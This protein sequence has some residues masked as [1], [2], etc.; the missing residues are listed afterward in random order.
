MPNAPLPAN[1]PARLRAL[2]SYEILD[3]LPEQ[4]YDD[5]AR[6]AARTTGMPIALVS[7]VGAE[8]QWFKAR[9]GIDL[10]ETPRCVSFCAH[11]ILDSDLLE[12][13]DTTVDPRFADNPSVTEALRLRSYFG[14][15]ITT[16]DGYRLGA[17]CVADTV[18]R[19]LDDAQRECLRALGRQVASQLEVRRLFREQQRER[20]MLL[21]AQERLDLVI[22]ASC[23]GIWE[24]D[25]RAG[26][27]HCSARARQLLG[28]PVDGFGFGVAH[29]HDAVHPQDLRRTLRAFALHRRN[30]TTLDLDLRVRRQQGDYRWFR[31]RARLE[32]KARGRDG[33][34]VGSLS[35]V[36]EM[37]A[38]KASA[39]R[40]ASLL[41]E[42]QAQAHVGGWELDLV[43]D[44]LFWTAETF[45]IHD[46]DPSGA[47]PSVENAIKFYAPAAQPVIRAAV[48]AAIV[49][50]K[51]FC[52]E[53]E[54]ITAKGR[55]IWVQATGRA[56][57]QGDTSVRLLGAFQD[58]TARRLADGEVRQ[59]KD[60]AEIAARAKGAFLAT[61]SHEIRTPMN[62]VLGYA[63]MLL[64][65]QLGAEQRE[66]AEIIHRSGQ[67][68]LRLIDDILDFSKAEA[69]KLSLEKIPVDL[70]Q[71]A[72]DVVRMLQGKAA[73]KNIELRLD[74]GGA[75]DFFAVADPARVRQVLLNLV[76]NAVKFTSEGGV[77]LQLDVADGG[78]VRIE[79]RDSGIGIPRDQQARLFREFEQVDDSTRRRFGGTGL[80]L[81]ISKQLVGAMGGSIG[82]DSEEGFGS[83]FWFTLP[84]APSPTGAEASATPVP[85]KEPAMAGR[86]LLAE[87]NPLN[88]K[89]ARA[90]LE[91]QGLHVDLANDG[92]EAISLAG[93][94]RYDL[95]L[96]DCVMPGVDGFHAARAIREQEM[97]Q[98]FRV[99]I[100]ALTANA[101]AEDRAACLAAGMDDFVA[102]PFPRQ[103]LMQA[104]QKWLLPPGQ[105]RG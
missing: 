43:E 85:Q 49:D 103:T 40:W 65:G 98:G 46:L 3:S 31:V 24:I 102:K 73:D 41:E 28:W 97:R 76:G 86:V 29:W 9:I 80:G 99:P 5:I 91:R 61:M 2:D 38:A 33:N 81:A 93:Q 1:E 92:A 68:L 58:I 14:A 18:P 89:L 48:D 16:P 19:Q 26:Q 44:R 54:L 23:D 11:T 12:C 66:Q 45:R 84:A 67:G 71:V 64:E 79:V 101:L 8:R 60:K 74:Y 63:E 62:A 94:Q 90:L 30:G 10:A 4:V 34:L 42:M 25:Q 95:I 88:Q 96:M 17:V 36:H 51:P 13:S 50:G 69:G 15:P 75:P 100:V 32:S 78:M 52:H 6:L 77:R 59:A 56:E 20:R 47:V 35:D 72:V 27:V 22:E 105:R 21:E 37:H 55:R 39:E 83:T 70:C 53:L 82:V 87:D 57:R 7:M 104:L